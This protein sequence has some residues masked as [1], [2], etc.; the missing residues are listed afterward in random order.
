MHFLYIALGQS[1]AFATRIAQSG[2][3]PKLL[4]ALGYLALAG[5][6]SADI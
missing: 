1:C 3:E 5:I 6:Y 4:E 2:E